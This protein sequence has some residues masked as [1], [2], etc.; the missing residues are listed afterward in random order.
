MRS[1]F[2][3]Q[4]TANMDSLSRKLLLLVHLL[5][6]EV[7]VLTKTAGVTHWKLQ[8]NNIVPASAA[9]SHSSS[10]SESDEFFWS[11]VSGEDPEFSVVMKRT[12]GSHGGLGTIAGG[13][14]TSG[15]K[16]CGR[17]PCSR[18]HL[19]QKANTCPSKLSEDSHTPAI[20]AGKCPDITAAKSPTPRNPDGSGPMLV[21]HKGALYLIFIG[22]KGEEKLNPLEI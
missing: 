20:S 19:P 15:T 6:L 18:G 4:M 12:T 21:L 13:S 17:K 9:T 7:L 2:L 5:L 22:G 1:R 10:D 11:S 14:V 3:F 16:N 8:E